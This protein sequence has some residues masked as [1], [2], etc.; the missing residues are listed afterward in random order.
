MINENLLELPEEIAV[1]KGD[2]DL[3]KPCCSF[4]SVIHIPTNL[5]KE[6]VSEVPKATSK[7]CKVIILS[8]C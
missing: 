2:D 8:I 1:F 6:Y 3:F 4:D 7:L 5:S